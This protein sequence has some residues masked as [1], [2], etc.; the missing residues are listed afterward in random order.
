MFEEQYG[1]LPPIFFLDTIH[2]TQKRKKNG[3]AHETITSKDVF[4]T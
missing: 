3:L 2:Q 4:Q 1:Y